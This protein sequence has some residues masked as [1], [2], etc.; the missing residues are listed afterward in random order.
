MSKTGERWTAGEGARLL[1][2]RGG[3]QLQRRRW[4]GGGQ[5]QRWRWRGGGQLQRRHWSGGGQL[6]RR[7][8]RGGGQL[9]QR[10]LRGG[11]WAGGGAANCCCVAGE[12]VAGGAAISFLGKRYFV[13][14]LPDNLELFWS[15]LY[16]SGLNSGISFLDEVF[17]FSTQL[18]Y[19]YPSVILVSTLLFWSQLRYFVF[20]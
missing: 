16:Y 6:Q 14:C 10:R 20:R 3:V 19:T 17:W 2:R 15:Q 4:R 5:L 12:R 9:Q 8:W 11:S 13:C 1:E 7:R 18:F